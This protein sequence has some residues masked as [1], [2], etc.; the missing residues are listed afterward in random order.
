VAFTTSRRALG[1]ATLAWT[2]RAVVGFALI[3]IGY[4]ASDVLGGRGGT[5]LTVLF[6]VHQGVVLG[7]VGLRASWMARALS[8]VAPVQD[9][10]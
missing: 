5:A 2:A 3:A 10:R 6:I 9:T 1:R 4:V 8:L 7:R